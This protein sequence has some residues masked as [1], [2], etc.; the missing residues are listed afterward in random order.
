MNDPT[1]KNLLNNSGSGSGDFEETLRLIAHLPAPEGLAERVEAGVLA[2]RHSAGRG[3]RILHWPAAFGAG[4]EWMRSA[5]AAAIVFVVVGGGWGVYTRVQKNQPARVIMMP[6]VAAPGGFSGA[7]ATRTPNTLNGPVLANPL[8]AKPGQ[9]KASARSGLKPVKRAHPS[10]SS[11]AAGAQPA[12][13]AA[14]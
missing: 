13:A 5:A 4:S 7:G 12:A 14:K 1:Q 9:D 11:K 6:R 8:T 2:R 10:A 3:G